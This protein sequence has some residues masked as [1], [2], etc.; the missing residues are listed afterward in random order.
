MSGI[1]ALIDCDSFFVS[2]EQAEKPELKG[3]PVCVIGGVGG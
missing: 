2:C 1:F 3:K